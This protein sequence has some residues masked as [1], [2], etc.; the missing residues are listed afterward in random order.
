MSNSNQLSRDFQ[1]LKEKRRYRYAVGYVIEQEGDEAV[2]RLIRNGEKTKFGVRESWAPGRNIE[3]LTR[4]DAEEILKSGQWDF[5]GYNRI[6]A[7]TIPTKIFD[8]HILFSFGLAKSEAKSAL[9]TLDFQTGDQSDFDRRTIRSLEKVR[10]QD[11]FDVYTRLLREQVNQSYEG[12]EALIRRVDRIPYR[13]VE[14]RT[15]G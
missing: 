3:E 8:A 9:E 4:D 2:E 11:F 10:S 1:N 5:Y 6:E 14:A 12:R 13:N 15:T 7:L